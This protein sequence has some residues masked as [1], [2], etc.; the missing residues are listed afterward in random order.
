VLSVILVGAVVTHIANQDPVGES[1][2]APVNLALVALV[3]WASRPEHRS[4][5][6]LWRPSA[7]G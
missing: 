1:A 5:D 2:A 4:G 3:A 7:V 6:G